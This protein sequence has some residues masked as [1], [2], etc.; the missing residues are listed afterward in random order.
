MKSRTLF[1]LVLLN[2]V[3]LQ[4]TFSLDAFQDELKASSN[5][6]QSQKAFQHCM[7]FVHGWLHHK[8]PKTGLI[9]RNLTRDWYWNAKDSAADN[10]PFMVLTCSMLNR[11]M[12]YGTMH[13]MLQTEI[14][15]TNRL[16]NLPD[17]FDFAT[18]SFRTEKID[19]HSVIFGGSEYIKDGLIPLTEWLGHSPWSGRMIG[20]MDSIWKHA[21]FETN[22][23][24]IPSNDY[25]INGE[26]LQVLCR[27]YWMT[28]DERYRKWAFRISDYYFL[29]NLPTR[30]NRLSLDDH[31]CEII[32]GLAGAYYLAYQCDPVRKESYYEPIHEMLD[33][34]LEIGANE[35]GL[36][37]MVIDPVKGEVK[38]K[39]L[40]DNWGYDYNAFLNVALLEKNQKYMNAIK[41]VLSNII[42]NVDYPWE[43]GGSDGMSDSVEGG[44][45]LLNRIP[46]ESGFDWVDQSMEILMAKQRYDGVIEG[47]H[48]DGNFARTTLMYAL[49]KTQGTT[50]E[51]WRPDLAWGAV[52]KNG[53]LILTIQSDWKWSGKIKFDRPRHKD[54]FNLP[55]DYPRIN[56]FPEWFTIQSDKIYD[57]KIG[58]N[59]P[60]IKE[61][62]DLLKSLSIEITPHKPV[63]IHVSPR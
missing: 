14:R 36:F 49:W 10:Y 53:K 46:D 17:D 22:Y 33:R 18:Q 39:E 42:H 50:V 60:L 12:F 24:V 51:P 13:D 58:N 1:I 5:A 45:N 48:G 59:N 34:I 56:Q 11:D 52:E 32:S 7:R 19:L 4:Q 3:F 40:T 55:S 20:I 38:N 35:H 44:L 30:G 28:G 62:K 43:N 41:H 8:D 47:W 61:G 57:V 26:Q 31:G 63:V 9:P 27:L 29:E 23:G 15:L 25:E 16:D 54:Y 2:V 21:S 6:W 37:Y